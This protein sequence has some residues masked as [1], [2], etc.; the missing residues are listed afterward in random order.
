MKKLIKKIHKSKK[1]EKVIK[2]EADEPANAETVPKI[3]N[4]TVA[5]HRE[6]VLSSA[7]KY[8]Y[9]LQ[10]SK[11]KIVM[12]SVTILIVTL[13]A[14]VSYCTVALY[15]LQ[16]TSSFLYGVTRVIP[17]PVARTSKN[18]IAYENYL[19]ELRHYMHYYESQQKL[20]F[21]SESGKQQLGEFK[22]QA[23]KKV[24][25]DT[26]IK[27]LAKE[28]G[29]KVSDQEVNDQI[30][31]LRQ[32]NRLGSNDKVFED[33]LRDYWGWSIDDFKRS[34][35]QQ[36]LTEKVVAKLD[37]AT[38]EKAQA[39]LNEL[40]GGADFAAVAKK[41]SDDAA[42]KDTGGD[43]GFL[44]DKTNRDLTSQATDT[45]FKMQPGQ[46]SDIINTGYSLEIVKVLEKK[47]DKV[48][49]AHILFNFKQIDSTLNNL[50]EK[51]PARVYIPVDPNP[52]AQQP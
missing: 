39:A 44:I 32:Q 46:N 30:T 51:Q 43:Y 9:P 23:L 25:D 14:F 15:K 10:H 11:H 22:K 6:E 34:L 47:D 38:Q 41:Y 50:K 16:S 1:L 21:T 17:F 2:R 29:V 40:K 19:F 49:A 28:N 7:R 42:T 27:K 8:I 24:I 37:T 4:D 26:Y 33:V 36:M 5:E 13:V 45:L 48:R 12:F 31:I 52:S 18:F 3:T 35:R 20:D